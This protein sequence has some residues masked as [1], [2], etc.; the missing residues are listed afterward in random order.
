MAKGL[1]PAV[2]PEVRFQY[3]WLLADAASVHLNEKFGDGSPLH[4]YDEY[5]EVAKKYDEWWA[6]E[7]ERILRALCD[8][9]G[10]QFRQNTI[11]VHVAPWFYAFSSPMVLGVIFKDKD[12]LIDVLTHEI[13][14]RLLTDNTTYEWRHDFVK[15]WRGMFGDTVTKNTLVHIPVH[16]IMEALYRGPL[17]R[18]DLVDFDKELV[19]KSPDYVAAWEYVDEH[20]HDSIVAELKKAARDYSST[21]RSK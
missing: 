19:K 20:G 10:L 14:H 9:T 5:C 6:P 16:A 4:S 18:P 17:H 12:T 7:G 8:I 15:Q 1:T 21:V 3:A 13:I 11:D 2:I